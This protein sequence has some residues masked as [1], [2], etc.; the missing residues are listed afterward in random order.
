MA[1][2]QGGDDYIEKPFNLNVLK[3]EIE[4][5]LRR[6]YQYKVN[7][8]QYIKIPIMILQQVV[9]SIEKKDRVD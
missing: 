6:T 7:Q 5:I 4:A 2:A 1:I 9:Y 3:A 8:K